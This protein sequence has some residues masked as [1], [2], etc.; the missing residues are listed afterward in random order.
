MRPEILFPLFKDIVNLAGIGTKSRALFKKLTGDK[1]I[2]I[3]YHLPYSFIDRRNCPD[4]SEMKDGDVVTTI[5]RVDEYFTRSSGN[6]KFA[7]ELIKCSNETGVIT[8]VFF[9]SYAKYL[10]NKLPVGST[11]VISGKVSIFDKTLQIIHPDYIEPISN[12]HKIAIIEPVYKMTEGIGKK[13]LNNAIKDSL[14]YV[15]QLPEWIDSDYLKNKNWSGWS[16]SLLKIHNPKVT[17]DIDILSGNRC[18]LAY[19][20]LLANQLCLALTKNKVK[21]SKGVEIKGDGVLIN[22]L[23]NKLD[24]ELTSGQNQ[25]IKEIIQDAKSSGRMMRLLQGDVGSGKTIVCLIAALNAVEAGKQVAIMAP[26][27]ILAMQHYNWI[28]K[29]LEGLN[30]SANLL[31]GKIKGCKRD[32]ILSGLSTGNIDIIIGTHALFQDAVKF[33][34]LAFIV[35]DE[36]HR[37]GVKQRSELAAKGNNVD[38]LMMSATPIPRT[39][40][41]TLYGDMDCSLLVEKP[42][43]R[44]KIETRIISANKLQDIVAALE[45]VIC[46]KEKIYWIC[47]F[48]EESE[49]FDI[50][51]A[52]ERFKFLDKIYKNKVGLVHGKMSSKDREDVMLNFSEGDIDILVATTVIEVGVDVSDA[53]VIVIENAD[54]FGLSQLHQL[55][56]RVGRSARES[57]C[58]LLY[59][60][61]SAE[62]S[63]RLKIMRDCDDGFHLAEED[64]RIRGGGDILGTR[65]SGMQIFKIADLYH[66]FDLLTDARNEALS[67]VEKDPLLVSQRGKSLQILLYLF[68]YDKYFTNLAAN[69][70]KLEVV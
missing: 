55:R 8:L 22:K 66:H 35:I 60:N 5:V 51:A 17:N 25:V 18:R 70:Q 34:D 40:T 27:E 14:K 3:V 57:S 41:M 52:E 36:Q 15:S 44:K 49:A 45:R 68:G 16:D 20:E 47:P 11:K 62:A 31:I 56:G 63:E 21:K 64:L 37:F 58:I 4:I 48:I 28:S 6:D 39:L 53:T 43:G 67:I 65:Q 23:L 26:T 1:I 46:K 12:L 32:S 61:T 24:F 30:C 50:T 29:I 7:S 19:D 59:K 38:I 10:K 33:K 2:D 9:N 13:R 69:N 54:R 42:V